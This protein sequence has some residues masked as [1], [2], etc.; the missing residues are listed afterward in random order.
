VEGKIDVHVKYGS[1]VT[2]HQGLGK[3]VSREA[4]IWAYRLFLN[5]EPENEQ[6]VE[7]H[8]KAPN[9]RVLSQRFLRSHEYLGANHS[10]FVLF[11]KS[12]NKQAI[13]EP[14]YV[15]DFV[16]SRVRTSSLSDEAKV[17]DGQLLGLP[18]L[19]DS[20]ARAIEWIG[21]LS[22]VSTAD[23]R[24][25]AM[26][27]GAGFGPWVVAGAKA[28]SQRGI[29]DIKLCAIEGGPQLR[30]ANPAYPSSTRE[31]AGW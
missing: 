17:R 28:A 3:V 23:S 26:E 24:Y 14:G 27:L 18:I 12:I 15:T 4:V 30:S 21:L 31:F 8:Q 1:R 10:D 5:R 22:S 9:L 25:R 2:M 20:Q 19:R 16:G 13:S 6:V 29:S 7:G 11:E